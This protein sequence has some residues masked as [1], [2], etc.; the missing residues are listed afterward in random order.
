MNHVIQMVICYRLI[1][2]LLT[3]EYSVFCGDS[4]IYEYWLHKQLIFASE[5]LREPENGM[6]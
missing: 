5:R 3:A 1:L 2:L 6:Q 4:F